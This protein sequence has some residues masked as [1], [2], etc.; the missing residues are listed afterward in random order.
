MRLL[1]S[2]KVGLTVILL[3]AEYWGSALADNATI[4]KMRGFK[5]NYSIASAFDRALQYSVTRC[6]TLHGRTS[7]PAD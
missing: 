5:I 7:F 1:F 4:S 3:L 2:S 6:S